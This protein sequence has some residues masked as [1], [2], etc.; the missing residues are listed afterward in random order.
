MARTQLTR[1][2]LLLETGRFSEAEA[3]MREVSGELRR[4]S[5]RDDE[6]T[7][8]TVLARALL[9]QDR[10]ADARKVE[11]RALGLA[12]DSQ[13]PAIRMSVAITDARLLAAT[14]DH[15]P[16]RRRLEAVLAEAK[17]LGLL[18]LAFEAQL[19]L[20]KIE[21]AAGAGDSGHAR[22]QALAREAGSAGFGLIAH[23]ATAASR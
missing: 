2:R 18:G 6:I 15:V 12:R 4:E 20:G 8:T 23:E 19:A 17:E 16:A 10:L 7:A 22:L 3:L 21:I 5:R 13:N 9:A 14:G 11:D 1:G